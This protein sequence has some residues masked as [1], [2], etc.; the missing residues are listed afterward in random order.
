MIPSTIIDGKRTKR[1]FI[2]VGCPNPGKKSEK[3]S[4]HSP[5]AGERTE[6]RSCSPRLQRRHFKKKKQTQKNYLNGV[7]TMISAG[8]WGGVSACRVYVRRISAQYGPDASAPAR[9]H[10]QTTAVA[11]A[12][13]RWAIAACARTRTR[14][15]TQTQIRVSRSGE[16]AAMRQQAT[17]SP[18]KGLRDDVTTSESC[19]FL[20]KNPPKKL[21]L[22]RFKRIIRWFR[23]LAYSPT[24]YVSKTLFQSSK[25][26]LSTS[27]YG[28]NLIILSVKFH[29]RYINS[30]V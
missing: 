2:C 21:I 8:R 23:L 29:S 7:L 15:H 28:I 6:Q 22:A 18:A 13:A 9:A 27:K 5:P 17:P 26:C 30:K 19:T 16:G 1:G 14:T 4:A 20:Y 3:K 24:N 25:H 10:M 11:A 12:A